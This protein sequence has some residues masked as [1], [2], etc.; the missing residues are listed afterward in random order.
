MGATGMLHLRFDP[1]ATEK[2]LDDLAWALRTIDGGDAPSRSEFKP[3]GTVKNNPMHVVGDCEW[4][5]WWKP[6]HDAEEIILRELERLA[7]RGHGWFIETYNYVYNSPRSC[8]CFAFGGHPFQQEI[9]ADREIQK[10]EH[11]CYTCQNA[12]AA[13]A[14]IEDDAA[15]MESARLWREARATLAEAKRKEPR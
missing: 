3:A 7:L 14:L 5:F 8:N 2:Q 11:E 10:L 15:L 13:A 9:D 4:A 1:L 12:V 6:P